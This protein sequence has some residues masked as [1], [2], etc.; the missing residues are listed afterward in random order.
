M[1][2]AIG[3]QCCDGRAAGPSGLFNLVCVDCC[4]A[5]VMRGHPDKKIAGAMLACVARFPGAPARAAVLARVQSL[6]GAMPRGA[7]P[8]RADPDGGGAPPSA[9]VTPG[10]DALRKRSGR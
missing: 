2:D 10:R 3:C 1:P 4:A 7:E 5:L 6:V 9:A 8:S